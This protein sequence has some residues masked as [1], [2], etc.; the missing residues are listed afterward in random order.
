[1]WLDSIRVKDGGAYGRFMERVLLISAKNLSARANRAQ[2]GQM[3]LQSH[4]DAKCE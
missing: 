4:V 3:A 2:H 1:M